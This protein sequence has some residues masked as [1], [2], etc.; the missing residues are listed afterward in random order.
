MASAIQMSSTKIPNL[1]RTHVFER[2]RRRVSGRSTRRQSAKEH[3]SMS[4]N[5]RMRAITSLLAALL[6]TGA[7]AQTLGGAGGVATGGVGPDGTTNASAQLERCSAPK[8]T[9]A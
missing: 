3:P 9:I 1:S 7:I 6:A 2:S 5:L 4:L 8:G